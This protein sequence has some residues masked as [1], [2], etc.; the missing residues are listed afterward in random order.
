MR[1]LAGRMVGSENNGVMGNRG[2][3]PEVHR[4][5]YG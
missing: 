1:I 5:R 3:N 2:T 4:N